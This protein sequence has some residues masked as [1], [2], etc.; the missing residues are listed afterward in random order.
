M[1]PAQRNAA[2]KVENLE[3]HYGATVAVKEISFEVA[4]GEVFGIVGPNGAGKTTTVECLAGLRQPDG[5]T[6]SVLGMDPQ[7]DGRKLRERVGVQ[8]QQAALPDD[9]KVWEALDLYESFYKTEADVRPLLEQWGLEEKANTRFKNLSG[10]QKQRLFIALSLVNEPDLVF[11]D[12]ITTGLDPQARRATWDLI[13][14]I[15]ERGTTVVLVTHYMDEAEK[16]CDRVAI[17]DNG[18]VVALD[19]PE[20]LIS[21][22]STETNVRFG[23][24]NGFD[25]TLL[26]DVAGVSRVEH[27]AEDVVVYGDGPLLSRTVFELDCHG[28]TPTA[29]NVARPTLEDVFIEK[30]GR[31]IRD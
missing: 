14:E 8:L 22:V 13:R 1:N 2:I 10:G 12:E 4:V 17:V 31:K 9:L 26:R 7:K 29:V 23:G 25:T 15:R 19:S 3:K 30:T 11:L 5:G 20:A 27:E 16:L 24:L 6:V 18:K 28:I 21:G